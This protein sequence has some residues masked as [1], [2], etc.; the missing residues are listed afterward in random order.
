VMRRAAPLA[1]SWLVLTVT[2]VYGLRRIPNQ[3]IGGGYSNTD[4]EWLRWNGE[5]ILSLGY[6]FD[7]SPFNAFAGMGSIYLPNLPWFS[8][9]A[10]ALS[11]PFS[12]MTVMGLSYLTYMAVVGVSI[13][14]LTRAL[15]LPWIVAAVAAQVHIVVFFPPFSFLF[16]PMEWYSAAPTYAHLTAIL[17]F[18]VALFVIIGRSGIAISLAALFAMLALSFVGLASGPFTI[19]FLSTPYFVF[20]VFTVAFGAARR[21]ELL[22]K[23]GA[24]ALIAVTLV[25]AGYPDYLRAMA[26]TSAR[27][28]L[29][30]LNWP[31]LL[32]P[33]AWFELVRTYDLCANPRALICAGNG[34]AWFQALGLAGAVALAFFGSRHARILGATGVFYSLFVLAYAYA[35]STDWLGALSVISVY[36]LSWSSYALL[37]ICAI[38]GVW[39]S[40]ERLAFFW[41]RRRQPK[42][43]MRELSFAIA[44]LFLPVTT[45]V[46]L[47]N[48]EPGAGPPR[49]PRSSP[50]ID[51]LVA[52][53]TLDIGK[54][55]SGY[56]VTVWSDRSELRSPTVE[57][58][59]RYVAGRH[60]FEQHYG[61]TF[62]ETDLWS[63]RVPTLEEYGQWVSRQALAYTSIL[64]GTGD[65][66]STYDSRML[67]IYRADFA[68]LK[69]LGVRFVI[70]DER[71]RK[72]GLILRAEQIAP[73]ALPVYLYELEGANLA[74]Y[75]PTEIIAE[76]GDAK[77]ILRWVAEHN[78]DLDR[79]AIVG[80]DIAGALVKAETAG[81][82]LARD[83]YDL[84]ASSTGRS[85]LLLPLQ[86]THCLEVGGDQGP[87][88]VQLVR[89][90]FLQ[91]LVVF[92]GQIDISIRNGLGL[93][94]RAKC[95]LED[96]ADAAQLQ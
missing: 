63:L 55:F 56:T 6:P 90:N 22:W 75:S 7:Y 46:L 5:A 1:L 65:P 88:G 72:A 13:V 81:M 82:T 60:Y 9:G 42:R 33:V 80:G 15:S 45:I 20:G 79:I 47:Q 69:A 51:Y 52:E 59:M 89:A 11:L 78:D 73:D 38:G 28:P 2:V 36:F 84:E 93:L 57:A 77:A 39:V 70:T 53:G 91:T 8:P 68:L 25:A 87:A 17:N 61:N 30:A 19:L 66:R 85:A 41:P 27:A 14:A 92:E 43:W 62:T 32:S 44:V 83:G 49:V 24:L 37:G 50:I 58:H 10:L 3:I 67:R 54:Q 86:Y 21:N 18:G 71:H 74:T 34:V 76:A 96:A 35:S 23:L 40:L 48:L 12:Q 4:G 95:G 31:K 26:G 29:A 16:K 64:M 94:G